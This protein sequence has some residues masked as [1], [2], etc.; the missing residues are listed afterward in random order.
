MLRYCNNCKKW[1]E[2][3]E[4]QRCPECQM[5]TVG[6]RRITDPEEVRKYVRVREA[7]KDY[8][9]EIIRMIAESGAILEGHFILGDED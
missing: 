4:S 6:V 9:E 1:V 5:M 3:E 8:E 2:T 7:H